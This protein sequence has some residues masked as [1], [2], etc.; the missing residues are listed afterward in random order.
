MRKIPN[1]MSEIE[2]VSKAVA[3]TS[4]FGTKSVETTEKI[5]TFLAKVF[6]EPIEQTSGMIG[7]RLKFIRWKRQVR[8]VDEVNKI[9]EQKNITETRAVPPK[10]MIPILENA[11]LEEDDNLQDIW[12][13]LISNS[14]NPNFNSEIRYAYIEII[15]SIN[16]IDARVLKEF[17]E[18]LT[19]Q[20]LN[21]GNI[22]AHSV[23]KEE[24]SRALKISSEECII[25][26]YNLFRVQ[27]LAP[28]IL[29]GGAKLGSEP[30]TIYKGADRVTM[31]P[32]G[33]NF[34]EACMK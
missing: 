3:E 12:I 31:T 16:P 27:C 29:T 2:E 10:F 4:K 11:T 8:I 7:D 25:S 22:T 19:R 34:V 9:L 26:I 18:A 23:P 5:L 13:K 21:L 14:M 6:K 20:N 30:I 17:Y 28:A 24:L 32:L 33:R 1:K 15:K